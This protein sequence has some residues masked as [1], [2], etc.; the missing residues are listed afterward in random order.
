MIDVTTILGDILVALCLKILL[1]ISRQVCTN[2]RC[3]TL[4]HLLS[5]IREEV[6]SQL[7]G[8]KP[9]QWLW[10]LGIVVN[11]PPHPY[12]AQVTHCDPNFVV[13]MKQTGDIGTPKLK[14]IAHPKCEVSG[15]QAFIER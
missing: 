2:P 12:N 13:A 3:A 9:T 14:P 5:R 1:P 6:C 10:S 11:C 8:Q 15:I 4:P 7:S